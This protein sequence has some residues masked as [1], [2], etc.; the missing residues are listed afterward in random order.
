MSLAFSVFMFKI[1]L[2]CND[3]IPHGDLVHVHSI[4]FFKVESLINNGHDLAENTVTFP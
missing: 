1:C 4:F 3:Y 2:Q